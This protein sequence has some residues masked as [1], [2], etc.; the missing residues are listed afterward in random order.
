[1]KSVHTAGRAGSSGAGSG[2]WS[3]AGSGVVLEFSAEFSAARRAG[4]EVT[5]EAEASL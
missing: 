5:L 3:G 4:S 2:V 1:M